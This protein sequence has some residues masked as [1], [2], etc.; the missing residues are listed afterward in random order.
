MIVTTIDT[1]TI[2]TKPFPTT[3]SAMSIS[4]LP[5][6]METLTPAPMPMSIPKAT[7]MI[8]MGNTTER[9]ERAS[10]PTPRP[11]KIL[12]TILYRELAKT[13]IKAG[14]KN[15]HINFPIGCSSNSCEFLLIIQIT[16]FKSAKVFDF[17]VC[18]LSQPIFLL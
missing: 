10:A 2:N 6:A 1:I 15:L 14:Q 9:P 4:F 8:M 13:P 17:S 11:I 12:S 7:T 16:N 3:R 5:M 18:T